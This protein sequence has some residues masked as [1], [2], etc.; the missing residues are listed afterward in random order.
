MPLDHA[1]PSEPTLAALEAHGEEFREGDGGGRSSPFQRSI[2]VPCCRKE[3][4]RFRGDDE[5]ADTTV[6]VL[7]RVDDDGVVVVSLRTEPARVPSLPRGYRKLRR[8]SR[9]CRNLGIELA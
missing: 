8:K 3:E 5:N 4:D 9:S 6:V 7:V 1:V 2:A